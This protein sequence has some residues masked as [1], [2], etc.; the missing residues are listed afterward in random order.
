MCFLISVLQKYVTYIYHIKFFIYFVSLYFF[1]FVL[2]NTLQKESLWSP[3]KKEIIIQC[4][5]RY[6]FFSTIIAFIFIFY[7]LQILLLLLFFFQSSSKN[8]M[9]NNKS[10]N[11]GLT[12]FPHQYMSKPLIFSHRFVATTKKLDLSRSSY[13]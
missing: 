9:G 13:A 10:E 1:K 4:Q 12:P 3:N 6:I 2:C 5:T 8:F 11:W 7:F